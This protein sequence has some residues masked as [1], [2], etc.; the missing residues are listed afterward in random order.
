M[1][2]KDYGEPRGKIKKAGGIIICMDYEE[3]MK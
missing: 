2:M 1:R 3:I